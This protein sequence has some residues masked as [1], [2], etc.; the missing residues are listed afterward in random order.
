MLM[1]E[2]RLSFIQFKKA[3]A[4]TALREGETSMRSAAAEHSV[5]RARSDL[6]RELGLRQPASVPTLAALQPQEIDVLTAAL[7]ASKQAQQDQLGRALRRALAY[8]PS[9]L[10]GPMRKILEP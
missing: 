9:P 4:D 7:R 8:V 2:W 10:R 5:E 3:P 6:A 1:Q